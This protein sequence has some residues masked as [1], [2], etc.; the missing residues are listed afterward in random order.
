[1]GEVVP[2]PTLLVSEIF[3]TTFQG[4]GKQAGQLCSFLRLGG[5]NL[6]CVWCDTPYAVFFDERKAKRHHS[7]KV[8]NPTVELRRLNKY[9]IASA[10]FDTGLHSGGLLVISGGEPVIQKHV[11]HD[12]LGH[13]SLCGGYQYAVETAGTIAPGPLADVINH[14]T[15]SPKLASS[16]NTTQE[17][18]NHGALVE[19][20]QLNA[21][22]K[23][24]ITGPEDIG[25]VLELQ[26]LVGIPSSHIWLMPAGTDAATLLERGRHVAS[27]AKAEGF[28]FSTRLHVLLYGD[29]K[30]T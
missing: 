17:A 10:V 9:E 3:G 11:L 29:T 15:V 24:V 27:C 14:W 19:Y 7:G 1:V 21:H 26:D 2:E 20:R 12:V 8:Y 30:G 23:F 16:G 18:Y 13:L 6:Q 22:F 5:C 4:E 28:N 25:Q